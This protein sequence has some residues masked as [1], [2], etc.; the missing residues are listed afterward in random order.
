MQHHLISQ[1]V[2]EGWLDPVIEMFISAIFIGAYAAHTTT[3][4]Q[5]LMS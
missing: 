1:V 3:H 2:M 4:Q 5:C